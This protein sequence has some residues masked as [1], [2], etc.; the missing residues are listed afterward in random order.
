MKVFSMDFFCVFHK[1]PNACKNPNPV[2]SRKKYL[3]LRSHSGILNIK[4]KKDV[5]L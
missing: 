5:H 4:M 1:N 3:K 2:M